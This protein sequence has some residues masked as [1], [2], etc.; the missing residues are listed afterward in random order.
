MEY[1]NFKLIAASV[2]Y[3]VIGITILVISFVIFEKL[4]PRTLWREIM[5]EHNT[6]LAIVAA[7]FMIAVALIISSAI[8]G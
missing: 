1:L 4:T 2:I 5:E 8:H 7:A 3:S 6:A